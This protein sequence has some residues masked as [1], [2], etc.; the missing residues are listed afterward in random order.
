MKQEQI[1]INGKTY[2]ITTEPLYNKSGEL[3]GYIVY[4]EEGICRP[5]LNGKIIR[6]NNN[7]IEIFANGTDALE[8]A[9]LYLNENL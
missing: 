8:Y 6:N 9:K 3:L 7:R 4:F 1:E 2:C 5:L